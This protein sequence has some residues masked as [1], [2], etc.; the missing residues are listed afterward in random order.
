MNEREEEISFILGVV[1]K[2]CTDSNIALVPK[3]N[4]KGIKYIAVL[5]NTTGKEYAMIKEE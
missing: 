5:D 1:N 4:K 2:I 3:E